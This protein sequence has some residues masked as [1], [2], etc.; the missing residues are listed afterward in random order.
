MRAAA[1]RC[2]GDEDNCT[3][4]GRVSPSLNVTCFI[5]T[6][7]LVYFTATSGVEGIH[8]NCLLGAA[9]L[10]QERNHIQAGN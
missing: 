2:N 1:L 10:L 4:V 5:L 7:L 6:L 8:D 3:T 9:I